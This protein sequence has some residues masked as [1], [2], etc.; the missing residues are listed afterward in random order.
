LNGRPRNYRTAV[1][2]V[3]TEYARFLTTDTEIACETLFDR[4][5]DRYLLVEVV[6]EDGYRIHGLLLHID[7]LGGK[8]WI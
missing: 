3:L 2:R 1:E 6:W 5:N 4:V 8:L 7:I